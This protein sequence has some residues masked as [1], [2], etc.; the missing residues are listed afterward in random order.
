MSNRNLIQSSGS[1]QIPW[2][3]NGP[4]CPRAVP[5]MPTETSLL[6][7]AG[8]HT[9]RVSGSILWA[10]PLSKLLFKIG[11]VVTMGMK[12]R[13][14]S[15]SCLSGVWPLQGRG[16]PFVRW[17]QRTRPL[18]GHWL[19]L[20]IIVGTLVPTHFEVLQIKIPMIA[21]PE[22]SKDLKQSLKTLAKL[23]KH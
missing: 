1:S 17:L 8:T 14:S 3:V 2:I 18:L 9:Q 19:M 13:W 22:K 15:M 5:M 20:K 16:D 10:T 23:E 6:P 4:N 7:V 21:R 12:E 11:N